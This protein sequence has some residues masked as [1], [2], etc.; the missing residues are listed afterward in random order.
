MFIEDKFNFFNYLKQ[1]LQKIKSLELLKL[2]ATSQ[3]VK[4]TYS[5]NILNYL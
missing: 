3:L 4:S 2:T 1:M 5:D